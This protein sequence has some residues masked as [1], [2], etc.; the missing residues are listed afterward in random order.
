M[1]SSEADSLFLFSQNNGE[2][3]HLIIEMRL[4]AF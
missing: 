4:Y 3:L 2:G 1:R